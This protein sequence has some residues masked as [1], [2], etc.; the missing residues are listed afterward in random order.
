LNKKAKTSNAKERKKEHTMKTTKERFNDHKAA[1]C[2]MLNTY[3]NNGIQTEKT[4]ISYTT[5]VVSID[6]KNDLLTVTGL[7]SMT[8]RKHIAWFA[9]TINKTYQDLKAVYEN[10]GSIKLSE[11]Y[12]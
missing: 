4:L 11:F 8:T 9:K 10:G 1:S 2:Y 12:R 7:Y 3:D 6:F 5:K